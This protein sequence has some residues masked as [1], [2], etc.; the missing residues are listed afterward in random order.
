MKKTLLITAIALVTIIAQGQVTGGLVAKYSFNGANANDEA[1]TN[2]GTVKGAV[3]TSDRFSNPAKAYKFT[4][5]EYIALPD[6]PAL[7]SISMTVSLWVKID[8]Y[9]PGANPENFIYTVINSPTNAYF[10]TFGM[11]VNSS[12]GNYFSVAQN[13]PSE[14]VYGPSANTNN[15]G[16]QHY[17][18][19]SDND[20]LKMYIDG[21]KQWSY[22]KGFT[23]TFTSDSVYI[24]KS[25]NTTYQGN[26][27]GSVD[28]IRVYNRVLS[29]IE[30]D[31]LFNEIDPLTIGINETG[32]VV[33]TITLFPNPASSAIQVTVKRA[34]TVSVTNVLGQEILKQNIQKSETIS[35]ST[36]E[37]GIYF[38]KDITTG[39]A[40]KF[41]KQ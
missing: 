18:L 33:N 15:A 29:S 17:V 22:Y 12:N 6:A 32:A 13:N 37:P 8:G 27:N 9:N 40:I 24:G 36:L 5:G 16:W 7:K 26:L 1:G 25:G 41:L 19:S 35:V 23:S 39:K 31:S 3:L 20:S 2:N 38:V 10:G 28:D 30:V 11:L 34:T 21:Q 14:S 4:N